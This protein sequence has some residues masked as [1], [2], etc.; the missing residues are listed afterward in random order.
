MPKHATENYVSITTEILDSVDRFPSIDINKVEAKHAPAPLDITTYITDNDEITHPS[1][2]VVNDGWNGYRY[3]MAATPYQNGNNITENP[4]IFASNDGYTWEI[5]SG[6]TNPVVAYPGTGNFN[7]DTNLFYDSENKTLYMFYRV[8]FGSTTE[9]IRVVSSTDGVT[10]G[11][12]ST[13]VTS[14]QS[15]RRL[16][17]PSVVRDGDSFAMYAIDFVQSPNKLV[18]MT[19]TTLTGGWGEPANCTLTMPSG[20]DAWHCDVRRWGNTLYASINDTVLGQTGSGGHLYIAKSLDNGS[21]WTVAKTPYLSKNPNASAWDSELYHAC[22]LPQIGAGGVTLAVYYSSGD[23]GGSW[24]IGRTT[25]QVGDTD[26]KPNDAQGTIGFGATNLAAA[27]LPVHPWLVGDNVKRAD[28]STSAGNATSGQTWTNLTGTLGIV[29]NTLYS[30]SNN[31]TIGVID[32]GFTDVFMSIKM[33]TV[34]VTGSQGYLVF[35]AL[36][37]SNFWRFG[38]NGPTSV[39]LQRIVSGAISGVNLSFTA[40]SVPDGSVLTARTA[41]DMITC[42]LRKESG[43]LIHSFFTENN[44]GNTNTNH[45]LQANNQNPRF[46]SFMVRRLI[47]SQ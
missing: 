42:T 19:S 12:P 27:T 35:R 36:N 4:S 23:A 40:L 30:G 28:S 6:L 45:G 31:N 13:L 38:M 20:R 18:K 10:W 21:T 7:S 33:K 25:A 37:S 1:V 34:P 8:V 32:A 16:V 14:T 15:V 2:I 29:S 47:E 39:T 24:L 11:S 3:W 43:E 44:F 26:T 17:S 22:L 5:P 46:D 9:E 41:G